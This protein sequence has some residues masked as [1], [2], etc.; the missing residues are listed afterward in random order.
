MVNTNFIDA[1]KR[2]GLSTISLLFPFSLI[3]Y[4]ANYNLLIPYYHLVCD[5]ELIHIKH[6]YPYKNVAKFSSDLDF[7]LLRYKPIALSDLISHV[8]TGQK[9][10]ERSFLLT[11]DDGY[12]QIY[13][14]IAP[15]LRERGIPAVF[16]VNPSFIDNK[17]L[18]YKNKASILME[19][20]H[21]HSNKPLFNQSFSNSNVPCNLKDALTSLASF[22]YHNRLILDN[23]AE[24]VGI[25]FP[26]YLKDKKPYLTSSQISRLIK[27][28]FSIGS[29]S[30][31]HPLYSDLT[32]EAQIEQ[33]L[34]STHYLTSIFNLNYSVF[35]FPH[36]DYGVSKEYF[37]RI[38]N[39]IDL[40]FGTNGIFKDSILTNIQRINFEEMDTAE[41]ILSRQLLK[42]IVYSLLNMNSTHRN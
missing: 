40:T 32:L 7:L 16:F 17:D 35:A 26:S 31:D 12:S 13:S 2:K 11:F 20:I 33:T 36:S 23:I 21:T 3:S 1:I 10:K 29:H 18:S 8:K 14:V 30:M 24:S 27:W 6:L 38:R 34:T 39:S 5:E 22:K 42:K 19:Y 15:I 25:N 37:M 4:L 41:N 9:I 28:G